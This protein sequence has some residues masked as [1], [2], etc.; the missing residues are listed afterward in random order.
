MRI[1]RYA[2]RGGHENI[3]RM[4]PD[5]GPTLLM[6]SPL[7]E[8]ANRTRRFLV[9]VMRGLA[10]T[11]LGSALPDLPGTGDSLVPTVAARFDD[12]QDAVGQ[13]AVALTG[14]VFTVAV[15]GGALLDHAAGAVARWRLSPETGARL[16]RDMI[17]STAVSSGASVGDIEGRAS[18]E[19]TMLAGNQL[20]PSMVAKL[21]QA[22]PHAGGPLRTLR[23]TGDNG[24]AD[25]FL[26]GAPLW[27][28]AE[29]GEDPALTSAVVDDIACW[30]KQCVAR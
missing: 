12:W 10:E 1:D 14:D 19:P 26:D 15:R 9:E 24:S 16:L 11:G 6:L 20:D 5:R 2:W 4:G 22:V 8:E 13:C 21:D 23:L 30:V 3:V 17:R 18:C 27:R 7:F 28:R 25:A 29:P